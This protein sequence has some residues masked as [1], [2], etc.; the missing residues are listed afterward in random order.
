VTQ[1]IA[2]KTGDRLILRGADG[3]DEARFARVFNARRPER[4]PAAVL[5]AESEDDVL[6]G[7]RLARDRGWKVAIRAGLQVAD[8]TS[9]IA[10]IDDAPAA[11]ERLRDAS[12]MKIFIAPNG[13]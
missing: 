13:S 2:P 10:G 7:V 6:E 11:F 12:A 5:V 1:S 9:E 4:Y 3:Y 8:L